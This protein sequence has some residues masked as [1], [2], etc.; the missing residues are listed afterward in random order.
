M[1][2]KIAIGHGL[3]G[4]IT[5]IPQSTE[6]VMTLGPLRLLSWR[7][8]RLGVEL[9][10][11]SFTARMLQYLQCLKECD[12][13]QRFYHQLFICTQNCPRFCIENYFIYS[14]D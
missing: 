12:T 10:E 6:G 9:P 13:A 3:D 4:G 7:E 2:A 14:S 11:I 5:K 8:T 1:S